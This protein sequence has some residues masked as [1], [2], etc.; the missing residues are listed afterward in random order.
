MKLIAFDSFKHLD[1]VRSV[2]DTPISDAT[3]GIIAIDKDGHPQGIVL[4][5]NWAHNSVMGHIA[6]QH[7]MAMRHLPFEALRYVFQ[8][9]DKGMFLGAIPGDKPRSLKFHL[10]LGF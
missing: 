1:Y 7:P 8:D 9:C 4:F 2:L 3:G 10:H 6:I 5:D